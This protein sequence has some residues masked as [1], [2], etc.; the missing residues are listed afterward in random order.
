MIA[1]LVVTIYTFCFLIC[2]VFLPIYLFIDYLIDNIK[3]AN[4]YYYC[5]MSNIYYIYDIN[6]TAIQC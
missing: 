5:T 6:T 2:F 3:R 1:F 4:R